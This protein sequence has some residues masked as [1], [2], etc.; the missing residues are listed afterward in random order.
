MIVIRH[1]RPGD[2]ECILRCLSAAFEPFR[3]QYTPAAFD[4]TVLTPETLRERMSRMNVFVAEEGDRVVGTIAASANG[5]VGHLRGMAVLP[6]WEGRGVARR[7][8]RRALDDLLVRGCARVTLNTTAPLV[9]ASR[10]YESAGFART[11]RERDFFGMP[12]YEHAKRLDAA[13]VIREARAD[14]L[15]AL[16]RMIN[17]A[18][19]VEKDFVEGDRLSEAELREHFGQGT[20]LLAARNGEP[21]V[22]CVFLHSMAPDRMYLGLLAVDPAGQ[23]HGLGRLMMAAAERRCREARCRAID[24]RIVSLRTELPPFYAS[25][26]FAPS[27]TAAFEDPR[28][29]KPAHFML[30][31]LPLG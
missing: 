22:A 7:L 1:A 10:F 19:L 11:G 18:Y 9:R 2:A 25:L 17:A 26:G 16:L 30:M 31:T 28:L 12:I 24:I 15:P 3:D 27:G 21:P 8:L 20:F 6:E 4:D 23:R 29:L 14:D 5:E 13:V